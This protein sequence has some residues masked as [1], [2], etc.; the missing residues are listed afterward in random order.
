MGEETPGVF[1]VVG[2]DI[3]QEALLATAHSLRSATDQEWAHLR[4][5]GDEV[6]PDFDD[7]FSAGRRLHRRAPGRSPRHGDRQ[8]TIWGARRSTRV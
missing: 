8:G 3:G 5:L 4:A 1:A 2:G 6:N 7:E